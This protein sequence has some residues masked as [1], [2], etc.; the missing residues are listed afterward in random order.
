MKKQ[1]VFIPV[2][3]QDKN[4]CGA[5]NSMDGTGGCYVKEQEGYFFTP[6]EL[7][8][9]KKGVLDEADSLETIF[10]E[11][12]KEHGLDLEQGRYWFVPFKKWLEDNYQICKTIKPDQRNI[13]RIIPEVDL[14]YF[15]EK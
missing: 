4:M 12:S 1:T 9:F 3:E 2:D 6:D 5:Y 7:E 13:D 10:K 8:I 15:V 11:Y 14:K